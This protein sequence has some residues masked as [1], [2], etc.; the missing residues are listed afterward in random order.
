VGSACR[1]VHSGASRQ[2]NIDTLFF[3][4]GWD[5]YGFDKK[6]IGTRYAKLSY[7]HPVGS[8]GHV[9]HFDSS[10]ARNVDALFF[11]LRW[12]Q[13]GSDKKHAITRYAELL[14]LHP[15]ES[16][17][18]VVHSH[19]S[20]A[21]NIDALFFMLGGTGTDLTKSDSGHITLNFYFYIQSDLWVT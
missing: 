13:C 3:M 6:C 15:V 10:R 7:L 11:M 4:L 1:V 5:Q 17:A 9:V 16:T 2:R 19:A 20:G 8:V 18:H 12:D 21:R 14:S